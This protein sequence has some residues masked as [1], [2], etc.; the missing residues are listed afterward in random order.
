MP[1][2]KDEKLLTRSYEVEFRT[3]DVQEG[4]I[5]GTPIVFGKKTRIKDWYG[6]YD[7]IIDSRALDNADLKDVRL[8]VNHDTDKI[9]LARS[10][11]NNPDSTMTFTID[12]TGMH[13][14][15]KLDLENN[16]EAK[17]VYSAVKRGDVDGMSFM[18]RVKDEEWQNI[19][20]DIPT[21]IIRG[22]S[23]VHEVSIV[24]YPAYPQTSVNARSVETEYSELKEMRD[25]EHA[26]KCEEQK[27]KELELE[28]LKIQILLGV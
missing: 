3:D 16:A 18:F 6:E 22:I 2:H 21:R 26:R 8:F 13:I 25:R 9:T 7:E 14:N 11:N 27:K 17:A 24:N 20:A 5:V 28:K 1:K 15:A 23:I 12:E 4:V 10:K 19:D